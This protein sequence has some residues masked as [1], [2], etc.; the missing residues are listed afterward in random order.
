[1]SD[2]DGYAPRETR[3]QAAERIMSRMPPV[4]DERDEA[5]YRRV[6]LMGR[7]QDPRPQWQRLGLKYTAGDP[8]G[9]DD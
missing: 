1:M 7:F 4:T 3:R 6:I 2:P 8:D 5:E 9:R